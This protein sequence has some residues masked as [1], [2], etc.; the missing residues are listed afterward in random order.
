MEQESFKF[1]RGLRRNNNREWFQ[2]HDQEYR[3]AK[4]D[5]LELVTRIAGHLS[6]H[7]LEMAQVDPTRSMFR[8]N[9]DIRF[10]RDKSP[11]KTH[12]GAFLSIGGK[13]GPQAGYY[14]H[15]EPGG[16]LLAG[17][18][19]MPESEHLSKIRQE[20]DY[21]VKEWQDLLKARDFR[22]VF[23]SLDMESQLI[24]PP[25]GYAVDN[26]ALEWLKLKS[27]TASVGIEDNV[28]LSTGASV[29]LSKQLSALTPMISFLN[30]ALA[31]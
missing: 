18:C 19:W 1:L 27:F 7:D 22:K 6:K 11:Y 14:I 13:K 8:I 28:W 29:K 4:A 10:S 17:G 23:G 3:S 24:R 2:A 9:R 26:P 5:F 12:F 21:N 20:I 15:A 31:E 25:K 30:R 16:G